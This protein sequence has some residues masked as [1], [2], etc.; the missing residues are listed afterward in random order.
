MTPLHLWV[1]HFPVALIVT[2]AAADVAGALLGRTGPRR[3]A[4]TLLVLGGIA[5]L[6]AMLTGTGA[7]EAALPRLGVV[8]AGA[9]RVEA[10]AQ[11]GGAGVWVLAGAAAL[12]AAWRN[13][14]DGWHGWALAGAA[15]VSAALVLAVSASGSAIAH[16]G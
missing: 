7:L 3:W 1:A 12:R 2:G 14:L 13:R 15:A 8:G 6:L 9:E 4:G 10:H 5:A 16:G 11:W